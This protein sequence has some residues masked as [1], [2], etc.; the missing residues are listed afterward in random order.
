M[1]SVSFFLPEN[2]LGKLA[3]AP[4][5]ISQEKAVGAAKSNL[6]GIEGETLAEVDKNLEQLRQAAA[7][8]GLAG[9]PEG[10]R[11]VY[12]FANLVAGMAGACRLEG[13][14]RAAFYLCE[15]VDRMVEVG[16]WNGKAVAVHMHAINLLRAGGAD[17]PMADQKALVDGLRGVA[18]KARS[19]GSDVPSAD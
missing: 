13:L 7:K 16:A 14:G 11:E 8:P 1:T 10:Q 5:G 15:T 3:L 6:V 9:D 4:G 2:R 12:G 17:M 18:T 19:L